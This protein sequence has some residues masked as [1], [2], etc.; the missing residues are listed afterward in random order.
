MSLDNRVTNVLAKVSETLEKIRDIQNQIEGSTPEAPVSDGN[1]SSRQPGIIAKVER[2]DSKLSDMDTKL[3]EINA[4]LIGKP[5]I[6]EGK[7][8]A[9][10]FNPTKASDF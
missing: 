2:I 10:P 6:E 7:L 4:A 5:L 1:I 8:N 3:D 9:N